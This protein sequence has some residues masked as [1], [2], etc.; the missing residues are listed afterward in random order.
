LL[1][2]RASRGFTLIELLVVISIIAIVAALL[3]PAL[4]RAKAKAYTVYCINNAKQ[5]TVCWVLYAGDNGDKLPTNEQ[6]SSPD[7]TNNWVRGFLRQ[8]PDAT[9]D[10]F[11]RLGS[12]WPYNTSVDIYRCP[13]ARFAVP[14]VLS[15]NATVRS[16]GLVRHFS[17]S[18]RMG[19]T[20][21]SAWVLG[22]Q[23]PIFKKMHDI[24]LPSSPKA[25]VFIDESINSVDDGFFAVDLGPTWMNSATTRHNRG[26]VLSFADGHAE[27]WQWRILNVEQDWWASSGSGSGSTLVDLRRV[28]DAVAEQ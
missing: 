4:A 2:R 5:L 7:A 11:I 19:A 24:R 21:Y 22:S 10:S 23:V 20:D 27:R 17:I 26:A 25:M 1:T 18:G 16:K 3:L 15:G 8:M 9:D 13:A 14:N 28:Q 6:S 12:L